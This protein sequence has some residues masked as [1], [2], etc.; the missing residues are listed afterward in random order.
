VPLAFGQRHLHL[1][2]VRSGGCSCEKDMTE[3]KPVLVVEDEEVLLCF[4]T[5]ALERGGIKVIGASSGEEALSALAQREIAGI[6]SDLKM[7]G[8]IG[9]AEIFD[10]VVEHQPKLSSRFLFIT[11]NVEDEY[12][13]KV[14]KRTGA[15]FIQK[16]FRIGLLIELIQKITVASYA[17]QI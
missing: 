5:T 9:G 1:M 15:L 12:A 3:T 7:P 2:S 8:D 13:I 4:L 14:R 6:V 17:P 16:P 11:G 10:W